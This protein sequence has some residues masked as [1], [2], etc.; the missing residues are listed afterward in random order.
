MSPVFPLETGANPAIKFLPFIAFAKRRLSV[1][2]CTVSEQ[3]TSF[4]FE[5]F[6]KWKKPFWKSTRTE[7]GFN[8][9][10]KKWLESQFE[11]VFL[12]EITVRLTAEY[13]QKDPR[14]E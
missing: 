9:Y 1:T 4:Q 7:V 14:Y 3:I 5:L 8:C 6:F 11:G 13:S 12:Q 10:T 2:Y